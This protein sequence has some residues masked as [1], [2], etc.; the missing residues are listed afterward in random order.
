MPSVGGQ[1]WSSVQGIDAFGGAPCFRYAEV[2]RN[3]FVKDCVFGVPQWWFKTRI[4][5]LA[6]CFCYVFSRI[7]RF[8]DEVHSGRKVFL[9]VCLQGFEG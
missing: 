2:M 8:G 5:I 6:P 3:D 9:C 7:P 1:Q 4:W